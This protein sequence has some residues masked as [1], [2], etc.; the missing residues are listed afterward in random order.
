MMA[1]KVVPA[2]WQMRALPAQSW[3]DQSTVFQNKGQGN[4]KNSLGSRNL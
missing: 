2:D 1:V 3:T 4:N